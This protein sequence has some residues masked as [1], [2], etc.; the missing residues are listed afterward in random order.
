MDSPVA[1]DRRYSTAI[2]RLSKELKHGFSQYI[3]TRRLAEQLLW[4]QFEPEVQLH[5][6]LLDFNLGNHYVKGRFTVATF[7]LGGQQYASLP[8]MGN[9]MFM[10]PEDAG[11]KVQLQT[12]VEKV[13]VW[14]MKKFAK[15]DP[16][17]FDPS[18]FYSN[19]GEFLT[20][21]RQEVTIKEGKFSFEEAFES[22]FF[23]RF[24]S[25][26]R[27]DGA[28]E[29]SKVAYDL[30]SMQPDSLRRAHYR[31]RLAKQL[32]DSVFGKENTPIALV[33]KEGVGKHTMME[34]I[35]Y[36]YLHQDGS[37]KDPWKRS[38]FWALNPNRV[39]AGMSIVG[40]WEKR[41]E[42][43]LKY[44]Q[45]PDGRE[46]FPDKLLIDNPVALMHIGKSAQNDLTLSK[47]LKPSLEKRTLQ[48]VLLATPE[49]WKIVQETDRGFSDLFQVARLEEPDLPTAVKMVLQQRKKLEVENECILTAPAIS[50]VFTIHRNYLKH[51]A[52]PGG[53]MKLLAQLAAKYR[54]RKA[55][56]EQ[57]REEFKAFS[58]LQENIFDEQTKLEKDEVQETLEM[59]LVG[60]P[61]AIRAL[62][63]AIHLIKA[64]LTNRNRPMASF[65]FVG[66]TGVGKTHAAKLL[67]K[68]LLGSDDRLLRFD[69]NEFIDQGALYRLIGDFYNPEGLLTGKVRYNPFSVILLDEI[70]KADTQIHDLLLQMLDDARLTD[71]MGRTVDFSN[72]VIIM[73]SNL[74]AREA[75]S[76]LGFGAK[77]QDN[78]AIFLKA[79]EREF[80]P[81]L[82]NRI[83]NIVVFNPLSFDEIRKIARL[84]INELLQRDGFVRRTTIV[85]VSTE[86]LD[87]VAGR[88]FDPTMG[89]RAL[90]RQIERD[91]TLLSA[92][93]LVKTTSDTPI[94]LDIFLENN[95]LQP[96]ITPLEFVS[97]VKHD[98]L[99]ELPG[100]NDSGRFFQQLVRRI[101]H[102]EREILQFDKERNMP[103]RLLDVGKKGDLDFHY[104]NFREKVASVKE[105][106]NFKI[107]RS[108]DR[109]LQGAPALPLRLKRGSVVPRRSEATTRLIKSTLRD[110][111]FQMEGL[112]ELREEY[113]RL[114]LEFSGYQSEYLSSF[115]DVTFLETAL[116]GFLSGQTEAVKLSFR[117][118]VNQAGD[119]EINWLSGIYTKLLANLD[120][121]VKVADNKK[122]ITAEGYGLYKLL[123]GERGIHL[124]YVAHKVP[125]PVMVTIGDEGPEQPMKVVRLYD[126][127]ETLTDLRTGYTN[128]FNI[129]PEELKLLLFGGI[130]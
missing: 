71:S 35:T 45:R 66:P 51:R 104:Y 80:R 123:T 70:E 85:N 23:A 84:Q 26:T 118:G 52:L 83:E 28:E 101:E 116:D 57:V 46:N 36:R 75:S 24:R 1:T 120:V 48:L 59:E 53:V 30:A 68:L 25:D 20:N 103:S 130:L 3:F 92:N 105:D 40:Q 100:E 87:W 41:F 69:M 129:S 86:A 89:G 113:R 32:Y 81:E 115:L 22:P 79:V 128:Q 64:K 17:N 106:L 76:T 65:L 2:S 94:I 78:S 82:V 19:K 21:I 127:G 62:S 72:T 102:I 15:A 38:A 114:G 99:P 7:A 122:S 4:F 14:L 126:G 93:Q 107:L 43:I 117:S 10:L 90:K 44:V 6:Y 34:E 55:D 74:G 121:V 61:A 49:E 27:F 42:A 77:K 110:R 54:L 119:D 60:Q 33:G 111:V 124:F 109:R 37:E 98:W 47:V 39:I 16:E 12:Q 56:A 50:Q 95:H 125:L 18:G 9:F 29:I 67:S 31:E 96:R 58:G 8:S 11:G 88:G 108:R 63:Q 13:V 91:L 73:T 97:P 112:Q 5:Q